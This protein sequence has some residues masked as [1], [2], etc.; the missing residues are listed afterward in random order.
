MIDIRIN[1][2]YLETSDAKIPNAQSTKRS[3]K[4]CVRDENT[5]CSY[6]TSNMC[7][8][9]VLELYPFVAPP[10]ARHAPSPDAN[11]G[12]VNQ[13]LRTTIYTKWRLNRVSGE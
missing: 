11:F 8:E 3:T 6:P 5:K 9:S 2:H 10:A 1:I 4:H 7:G 12:F 13:Q